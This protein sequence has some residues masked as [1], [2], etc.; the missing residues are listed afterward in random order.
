MERAVAAGGGADYWVRLL[1]GASTDQAGA[2]WVDLARYQGWGAT[3]I[4]AELQVHSTDSGE[5]MGGWS[6][7][8]ATGGT[9][10]VGT[11]Q[12]TGVP[13]T[14]T[15]AR[16]DWLWGLPYTFYGDTADRLAYGRLPSSWRGPMFA[17]GTMVAERGRA[18][19]TSAFNSGSTAVVTQQFIITYQP[20]DPGTTAIEERVSIGYPQTATSSCT[21][22]SNCTTIGT[23][24]VVTALGGP[25]QCMQVQ[26]YAADMDGN[27]ADPANDIPVGSRLSIG[28]TAGSYTYTFRPPGA[29]MNITYAAHVV[30]DL[31]LHHWQPPPAGSGLSPVTT[32][33]SAIRR[34]RVCPGSF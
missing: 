28:V 20:E 10:D 27:T 17:G 26:T 5:P 31:Y 2:Y 34:A 18:V 19:P 6:V 11:P 15:G 25:S 30:A 9:G 24:C 8:V 4:T 14:R 21:M 29:P 13:T 16:F 1:D 23:D 3:T 33:H 32:P 7:V 22:S 12:E